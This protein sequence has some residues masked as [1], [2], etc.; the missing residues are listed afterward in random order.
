MGQLIKIC[1]WLGAKVILYCVWYGSTAGD[2][3]VDL[4][5]FRRA[6]RLKRRGD[7]KA[8]ESDFRVQSYKLLGRGITH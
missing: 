2:E 7:D 3:N 5:I 1:L 8:P 6:Q 4:G